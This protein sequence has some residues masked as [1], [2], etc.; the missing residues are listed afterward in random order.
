M[1]KQIIFEADSNS[2]I[3]KDSESETS[4]YR[5]TEDVLQKKMEITAKYGRRELNVPDE[6][7]IKVSPLRKVESK[8]NFTDIYRPSDNELIDFPINRIEWM[9]IRITNS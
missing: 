3:F 1:K 9:L 4:F 6:F 5:M 8:D 7:T 2:I